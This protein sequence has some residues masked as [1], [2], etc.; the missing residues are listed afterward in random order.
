MGY[1][2]QS[3]SFGSPRRPRR[4]RAGFTVVE[5]AVSGAVM[6][7]GL[8]GFVHVIVVANTSA[9]VNME[10]NLAIQGA[11]EVVESIQAT[12]FDQIFATFGNA[13]GNGFAVPGLDPLPGDADGLVGQILFPT[14]PGA[15]PGQLVLREDVVDPRFDTPFD[16]NADT[17]ID[18]LDHSADYAILPV[19]VEIRWRGAQ[20][21]SLLEFA[22]V[23]G[24]M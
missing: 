1:Q 10:T 22:T 4:R 19:V 11:Q 3:P 13:P 7:V 21:P 23:V 5:L 9:R 6:V 18:G 15:L 16:L 20:G 12:R 2:R 14:A 17:V 24:D 8:L